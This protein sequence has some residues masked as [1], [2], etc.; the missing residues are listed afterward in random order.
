MKGEWQLIWW[1][2]KLEK[3]SESE[4]RFCNVDANPPVDFFWILNKR[5]HL[6]EK[7]GQYKIESKVTFTDHVLLVPAEIR[8]HI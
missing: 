5:Q 3:K 7:E 1:L 6:R 8:K 4:W 2:F